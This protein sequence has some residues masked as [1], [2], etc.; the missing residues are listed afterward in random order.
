MK[1]GGQ[2]ELLRNKP[3]VIL[4]FTAVPRSSLLLVT[5][6]H[7]GTAID[8]GMK[9][10]C[11][12][13]ATSTVNGVSTVAKHKTMNLCNAGYYIVESLSSATHSKRKSLPVVKIKL[14]FQM[15]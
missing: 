5:E 13:T 12:V 7:A 1:Q 2:L 4:A 6:R 11:V 14:A 10:T 8:H 15:I 3:V 9:A